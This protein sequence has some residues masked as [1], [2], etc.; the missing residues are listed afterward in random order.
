MKKVVKMITLCEDVVVKSDSYAYNG[1]EP[2]ALFLLSYMDGSLALGVSD[3]GSAFSR[4]TI[5]SV[6]LTEY[7]MHPVED[8]VFIRGYGQ[9]EGLAENLE[10]A[11]VGTILRSVQIDH[12]VGCEFL[13]NR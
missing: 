4:P 10:K 5:V 13:L 11:G 7:G 9:H 8:A 1:G 12:G 3:D 6:N 2:T